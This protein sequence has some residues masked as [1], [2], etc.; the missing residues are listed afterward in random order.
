MIISQGV[1]P[2]IDYHFFLHPMPKSLNLPFQV[3]GKLFPFWELFF[4]KGSEGV[5]RSLAVI[6]L[7]AVLV[8]KKVC[9]L[10]SWPRVMIDY[11]ARP[12]FQDETWNLLK[13]TWFHVALQTK[14]WTRFPESLF[15][16][17]ELLWQTQTAFH[18]D[19]SQFS[20]RLGP[21]FT[22]FRGHLA[23]LVKKWQKII[24]FS[25]GFYFVLKEFG[26]NS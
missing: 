14:T 10:S 21:S 6:S 23:F 26:F 16:V 3:R 5:V 13:F 2:R 1:S 24:L 11:K 12:N 7:H 9:W 20:H 18:T 19:F 22:R 8:F 4:G 25:P 15:K 17:H